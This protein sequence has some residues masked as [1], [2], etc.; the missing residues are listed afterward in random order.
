MN[1][2]QHLLAIKNILGESPLWHPEE[3]CLYWVDID[4]EAFFKWNLMENE[5]P[6]RFGVG[7]L[8]G[9]IAFRAQGGLLLATQKGFA[10]CNAEASSLQFIADPE[11][12]KPQTRL[13]DGAVDP[14][15]RFWCGSLGDPFN[16]ALYRFDPDHSVH[17]IEDGI[18]MAN[19]MAWSPDQ[20]T[21]YFADTLAHTVYAY[22]YKRL[23]GCISNRRV[24]IRDKSAGLPDG[25]TVDSE[26][27]IWLA[28]W[29]G[30]RL[31]RHDP[32]G[33]LQRQIDL[34]VEC[35]TSCTFGGVDLDQ[36]YITSAA[37]EQGKAPSHRQPLAGDLF[38]LLPNV[39]GLSPFFFTG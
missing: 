14:Q 27:F 34:P 33:K 16:N 3:Q 32:E 26:G 12:D 7:S 6:Q 9:A 15:G 25:L 19:G 24:F 13:N 37:A 1:N 23:E 18:G 2:I 38:C 11:A 22:D 31:T 30:W 39:T 21:F 28:W 35:P 5:Q 10:L 4:G 36:L 17:L 20:Q 29:G 8:L